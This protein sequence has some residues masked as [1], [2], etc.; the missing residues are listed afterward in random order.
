[1]LLSLTIGT[2]FNSQKQINA[3]S[4]YSITTKKV[5]KKSKIKKPTKIDKVL[6][7][8]RKSDIG[9][10]YQGINKNNVSATNMNGNRVFYAASVAKLPVVAFVQ[11]EIN[12]KKISGKTKLVYKS[13]ANRVP[14]AMVSAGTG[15]LQYKNHNTSYSVNDLLKWT[16]LH[17]DNQASNQLLYQVCYKH[18]ASFNRYIKK[19]YGAKSYSKYLTANQVGKIIKTIYSQKGQANYDLKHTDWRKDKI[20]KL[21]VTVEHKIGINI[22]Y[23]HDAAVVLG[24][25]PFVLVVMTKGWSDNQIS[26]LAAE[27]YKANN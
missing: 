16:I 14:S 24:K 23:N 13:Q 4:S 12:T 1:M 3:K 21:P 5:T 19:L 2:A 15:I 17:S 6:K 27:V 18:K 11:H 20:G 22:P 9:V 10:F 25:K 26:K 7:K 8:Y